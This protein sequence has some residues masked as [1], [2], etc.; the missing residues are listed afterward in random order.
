MKKYIVIISCLIAF[1]S[2]NKKDELCYNPDLVHNGFCTSDCPGVTGCDGN[3][4]CNE[5]EANRVGISVE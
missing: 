3:F 5:C 4:Y 1:S 2:C